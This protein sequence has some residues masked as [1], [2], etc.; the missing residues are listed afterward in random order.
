MG[1]LAIGNRRAIIIG[2]IIQATGAFSLCLQSAA[3][4]YLG[5]ALIVIGGGLYTPNIMASYGKTYLSKKKLLDAAF[6]MDYLAINVGSFLGVLLIGYYGE[7]YGWNVG[8]VIAGLLMILSVLVVAGTNQDLENHQLKSESSSNHPVRNILIAILLVALF[9]S[10]YELAGGRF[11]TINMALLERGETQVFGYVWGYLQSVLIF[12]VLLILSVVYTFRYSSYQLKLLTGF[13]L[14]ALSF[15]ILLY[16]PELPGEQHLPI[17]IISLVLFSV[18][19]AH[20]GPVIGSVVTRYA[21]PKYLAIAFG[22]VFIPTRLFSIAIGFL[23][24]NLSDSTSFPVI[25]GLILMI[26]SGL[27][28]ALYF[29]LSKNKKHTVQYFSGPAFSPVPHA[30]QNREA[31][32][33]VNSN[34][35]GT[36]FSFLALPLPGRP[37]RPYPLRLPRRPHPPELVP[38]QKTKKKSRHP[39]GKRLQLH[40]LPVRHILVGGKDEKGREDGREQRQQ[41]KGEQ[42]GVSRTGHMR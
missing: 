9:W 18:A 6:T 42:V 35:M 5:I 14:G 34:L 32:L 20:I 17:F 12:P 28:L 26:T 25:L 36:S 4:L 11:T 39:R 19:E 13:I 3:G 40:V 16:V 21:N 22:V 10:A 8:F 15:G 37:R 30:I 2:G 29:I 7:E 23:S 27:G 38:R 41:N 24:D 31:R 1:D 33:L